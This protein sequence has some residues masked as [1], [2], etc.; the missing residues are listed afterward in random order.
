M[1]YQRKTILE[2]E[3]MF[4]GSVLIVQ[5]H[6]LCLQKETIERLNG[7]YRMLVQ[8]SARTTIKVLRVLWLC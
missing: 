1:G 4:E 7:R 2:P 8:K 6:S 3:N 5:L